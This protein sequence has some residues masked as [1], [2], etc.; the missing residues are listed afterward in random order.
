LQRVI[1]A[2]L[3]WNSKIDARTM[4]SLHAIQDFLYLAQ[5]R[6]HSHETLGYLRDALSDFHKTKAAFIRNGSRRGKR[7]VI[8][9][10][11]IPKL[12]GLHAY[13]YHIPQ[14]G[15]SPQY[16][17]EITET[18]HQTMAKTAYKVTNRRNY[19]EQMC[20][21]LDRSDKLSYMDGFTLWARKERK[22]RTLEQALL[23]TSAMYRELA[24]RHISAVAD[25]EL[26]VPLLRR[27]R[28]PQRPDERIWHT[29]TPHRRNV[30]VSD[31]TRGYHLLLEAF[32]A[33]LTEFVRP[34]PPGRPSQL[35]MDMWTHIRI[36]IATIQEVHNPTQTR[37]IQALPP[38]PEMPHG[39]FNCVLV[40]DSEEAQGVGVG[41]KHRPPL[42]DAIF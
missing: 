14:M 12:A 10:F 21:Y 28:G 18:L 13:L 8:G 4:R 3:H 34:P 31:A 40:H 15:S 25:R 6:S 39:R 30:T 42:F 37:T 11:N 7:G 33:S 26:E 2:V 19:P 17:S 36:T 29:L 5:Y 16:S 1:L 41:G 24:M 22:R 38:S 23:G 35:T 20:R 27:Q 32:I 9:H